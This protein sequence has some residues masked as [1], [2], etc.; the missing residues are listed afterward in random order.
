MKSKLLLLS[1]ALVLF[2]QMGFSQKKKVIKKKPITTE[3]AVVPVEDKAPEG[4][5]AST[6]GK[7]AKSFAKKMY[8][9]INVQEKKSEY[10][11]T[12]KRWKAIKIENNDGVKWEYLMD[13]VIKWQSGS[14]GWPTQWSDM[15]YEGIINCDEFGCNPLFMIKQ[16]T[17]PTSGLFGLFADKSPVVDLEQRI[18][19]GLASTDVWFEGIQYGWT[20]GGCLED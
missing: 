12:I 6:A 14:S 11:L 9:A 17:E 15:I 5:T 2:S 18:K 10:T 19:D 20:P 8:N 16:K 4:F 13:V 1:L 3:L 7:Y